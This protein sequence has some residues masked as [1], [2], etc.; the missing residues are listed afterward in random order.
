MKRDKEHQAMVEW[1]KQRA[2]NSKTTLNRTAKNDALLLKI[3]GE[4][5]QNLAD[6]PRVIGDD[7][8]SMFLSTLGIQLQIL[9]KRIKNNY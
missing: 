7:V 2:K 1:A 9:S 3:A 6:A 5:L 4:T 8:G